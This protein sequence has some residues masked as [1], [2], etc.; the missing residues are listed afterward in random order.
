MLTLTRIT[1]WSLTATAVLPVVW[2]A[3]FYWLIL[4]TRFLVGHWPYYSHPDPKDTGFDLHYSIVI[5]SMM[6]FPVV[7]L[8]ASLVGYA[9]RR[10]SGGIPMWIVVA[11]FLVAVATIVFLNVEPKHFV[12]W[13]L[14]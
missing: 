1:N 8:V 5:W 12:I 14:D 4:R 10:R 2:L 6:A 11:P 3:C 7:G 9:A 13:L